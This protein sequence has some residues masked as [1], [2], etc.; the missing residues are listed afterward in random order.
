[1][2][3][4]G[5][6]RPNAYRSQLDLALER[7]N[8]RRTSARDFLD[9]RTRAIS[10]VDYDLAIQRDDIDEEG[11]KAPSQMPMPSRA[12]SSP[13]PSVAPK[14]KSLDFTPD[15]SPLESGSSEPP[16]QQVR[17]DSG[18]TSSGRADRAF[19]LEWIRRGRL[20][21]GEPVS[22]DDGADVQDSTVA[23]K[24]SGDASNRV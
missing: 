10:L 17:L 15:T 7:S 16:S 1:M 19:R 20:A 8:S 2:P 5:A 6:P 22:N 21:R 18:G 9:D 14:R 12:R 24:T 11:T 3:T 4:A 13:T 23:R